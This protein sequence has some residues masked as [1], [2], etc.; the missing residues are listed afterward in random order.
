MVLFMDENYNQI[1]MTGEMTRPRP[2]FLK[3]LPLSGVNSNRD[4]L[5]PSDLVLATPELETM[6]LENGSGVLVTPTTA[7]PFNMPTREEQMDLYVQPFM[8][9]LNRLHATQGQIEN[10]TEP[11]PAAAS[12]VADDHCYPSKH[13]MEEASYYSSP[14]SSIYEDETLEKPPV[15]MEEEVSMTELTNSFSSPASYDDKDEYIFPHSYP[16]QPTP[17]SSADPS[18]MN[19]T[20]KRTRYESEAPLVPEAPQVTIRKT[21]PPQFKRLNSRTR[22]GGR[23]RK[24]TNDLDEVK[25]N[26]LEKKRAR[27]RVAAM[28]C[29][30]RKLE[31]I[32]ELEEQVEQLKKENQKLE[33]N[34]TT[35]SSQVRALKGQI[36]GHMQ[37]GCSIM[38]FKTESD[39]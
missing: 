5:T 37:R 25:M 15:L 19:V 10:T 24:D 30:L 9:A 31:R 13:E 12:I 1:T 7:K 36:R 22:M 35:L 17:Q 33:K 28:K 34:A 26:Q 18:S 21:A 3:P 38:V 8:Q 14:P 6:V 16:N 39:F 23:R 11:T 2:E 29:R 27:N 32:A 4:M 20:A